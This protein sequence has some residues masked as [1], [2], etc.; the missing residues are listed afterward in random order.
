[1]GLNPNVKHRIKADPDVWKF[2]VWFADAVDLG[3]H[4][5]KAPPQLS[6][7][8]PALLE[9]YRVK[10]IVAMDELINFWRHNSKV[11]TTQLKLPKDL[12]SL[13]IDLVK[14]LAQELTL[15]DLHAFPL[16]SFVAEQIFQLKTYQLL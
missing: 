14:K 2:L 7:F 13:Q 15:K 10:C 6:M 9:A 1:M 4:K 11:I 12:I 16:D 5:P 8:W 3:R